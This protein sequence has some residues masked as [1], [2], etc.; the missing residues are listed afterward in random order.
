MDAMKKMVKEEWQSFS[1]ENFKIVKIV[2]TNFIPVKKDPNIS[3]IKKSSILGDHLCFQIPINNAS[4]LCVDYTYRCDKC[5]KEMN[6]EMEY[7][8]FT[9]LSKSFK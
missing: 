1:T 5:I 7:F 6:D 4:D 8:S 3:Y 9:H 2:Y